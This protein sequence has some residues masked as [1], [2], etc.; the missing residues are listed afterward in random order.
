MASK[1]LEAE[2]GHGNSGLLPWSA[3]G[4]TGETVP[5]LTGSNAIWT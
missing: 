1:A 5:E 4:D 2:I 3:F